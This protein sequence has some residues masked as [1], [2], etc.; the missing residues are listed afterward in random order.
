MSTASKAWRSIGLVGVVVLGIATTVGSGGG[1]PGS[2]ERM[3]QLFACGS[4]VNAGGTSQ[5]VQENDSAGFGWS[6]DNGSGSLINVVQTTWQ[7]R[8]LDPGGA[9]TTVATGSCQST[10]D[11][12]KVGYTFPHTVF[13]RDD[14][15]QFI[16]DVTFQCASGLPHTTSTPTVVLHVTPGAPAW[17]DVDSQGKPTQPAD[18]IVPVGAHADF[19]AT[20]FGDNTY[21]W[22]RSN[23]AGATWTD[24]AGATDWALSIANV[25]AS[26][27]AALLRLRATSR[28][29]GQ[30]IVS[31]AALLS[32]GGLAPTFDAVLDATAIAMSQGGRQ[33]VKLTLT[34]HNGLIGSVAIGVAGLP[35]GLSLTPSTVDIPGAAAVT[36]TLTFD[37]DASVSTGNY[38]LTITATAGALQR[39][40]QLQLTLVVAPDFSVQASATVLV[41][42]PG[43]QIDVDVILTP[44]N[45][46]TGVVDLSPQN[47]PAALTITPPAPKVAI[48]GPL[49]VTQTFTVKLDSAAPTGGNYTFEIAASVAAT[50]H[51]VT[52]SVGT[53]PPAGAFIQVGSDI[54]DTL[55]SLTKNGTGYNAKVDVGLGQFGVFLD[56]TGPTNVYAGSGHDTSIFVF[57]NNSATPVV[58]AAG[59][60]KFVVEG[61]YHTVNGGFLASLAALSIF[62][63]A[64]GANPTASLGHTVRGTQSSPSDVGQTVSG[65]ATIDVIQADATALKAQLLAPQLTIPA[66]G[67]L[68]VT[69]LLSVTTVIGGDSVD[70]LT[71][72]AKLCLTLPPGMTLESNFKVP[73]NWCH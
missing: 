28:S 27:D 13:R 48:G 55:E 56:S 61:S 52:I 59:E 64:S 49:P 45:G 47:V 60:L 14:G 53:Q 19:I 15:A 29:G 51:A 10:C 44:T 9:S 8:R 70:F 4:T 3:V 32:V 35:G 33:T 57:T 38:P 6:Y 25:Q 63:T 43:H 2:D 73:M 34:P 17:I 5:T 22:Q 23:D 42:A 39:Q 1:D 66:G 7:W 18:L 31:R 12:I 67:A 20:A 50:H 24:V 62:T 54:F 11:P 46:R 69:P 71:V 37:A 58:L 41:L 68:F 30:T 72:P 40:L 16:A 21:Q 26:D 36:Q 65:G